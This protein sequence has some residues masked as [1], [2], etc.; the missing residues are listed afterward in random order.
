MR[1][2]LAD[3]RARPRFEIVGDLAGTVET[4]ARL[5][6]CDL[7]LDGALVRSDV[8]LH[9]GAE[10]R[11]TVEWRGAMAPA[12]V[13]VRHTRREAERSYAAG[14]EFV[15]PSRELVALIAAVS[16]NGEPAGGQA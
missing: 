5:I 15:A 13:R 3:R 1:R 11:V 2:R 4:T 9:A 10:L 8:A 12:F 7:S 6:I 14:V 16:G